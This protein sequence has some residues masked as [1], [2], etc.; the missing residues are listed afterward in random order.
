MNSNKILGMMNN[1]DFLI[2]LIKNIFVLWFFINKE[3]KKNYYFLWIVN[4]LKYVKKN[5]VLF[6]IFL[7][8]IEK[9]K[10]NDFLLYFCL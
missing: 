3:L 7:V 6:F 1:D 5:V 4:F 9:F 10:S 2:K 8:I